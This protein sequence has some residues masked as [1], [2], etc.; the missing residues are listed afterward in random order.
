[1]SPLLR[2]ALVLFLA[3]PSVAAAQDFVAVPFRPALQYDDLFGSVRDAGLAHAD[4]S[5]SHGLA[6]VWSNPGADLRGDRDLDASFAASGDLPGVIE[7]DD[8]HHLAL[9]AS[10]L[11]RSVRLGFAVRDLSY[12]QRIRTAFDPAGERTSVE[13]GRRDY[14]A[15]LAVD[16]TDAL[17]RTGPVHWTVGVGWRT[18]KTDV[19]ANAETE[20]RGAAFDL[21]STVAWWNPQ[22]GPLRRVAGAIVFGNVFDGDLDSN[23]QPSRD[24]PR[25][26]RAGL[27]ATAA[28]ALA[29]VA[30]EGTLALAATHSFGDVD[31]TGAHVG[32]EAVV[33]E[34]F[35]ARVGRHDVTYERVTSTGLGIRFDAGARL[36]LQLDWSRQAIETEL[37]EDDVDVWGLRGALAF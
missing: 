28:T 27:T 13:V 5:T 33:D 31:D 32:L 10:F 37:Q 22:P 18:R 35:V 21:G 36:R 23:D 9:G 15:A 30:L 26:L 20:L 4:L 34:H 12:A 11:R 24:L 25:T 17:E 14:A 8:L 6:G 16:V 29:G 1:M 2:L 3:A 7:V 19:G